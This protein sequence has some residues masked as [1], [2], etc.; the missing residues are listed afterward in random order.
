MEAAKRLLEKG[1]HCIPL[2]GKQPIGEGWQ[3]RIIGEAEIDTAFPSGC[4]LGLLLGE[5]SGWIVDID[6]DTPEAVVTAKYLMPPTGLSFGRDGV[7]RAHLLYV[8]PEMKTSKYKDPDRVKD[9]M[10]IEIRSTGGQTM[11]PPSTHPNGEKVRWIDKGEPAQLAVSTLLRGV[12]QT[13]SAA[14]LAM[15]WPEG[16]RQEAAMHLSGALARAGW[17]IADI[18][19]FIEAVVVAAGDD[20][21]EMRLKV[22]DYAVSKLAKGEKI[23]GWP[24]LTETL[25]EKVVQKVR[26]WMGITSAQDDFSE[27]FVFNCTD[28]GNAERLIRQHGEDIRFCYEWGKWVIWNGKQWEI[29]TTGEIYRRAKET[30]RGIGQEASRILDDN[31][32]KSVLKWASTSES[33]ARQRDMIALAESSQ[34]VTQDTLDQNPWLL[35]VQNG[36][37]DLRTGTLLPHAKEHLLTKLCPAKFTNQVSKKWQVFIERVLPD[38]DVRDF[39]QRAVGYSLTGDTGEEVMMFL[40]GTGRNGKSKFIEALQHVLGDYASST[41]PEVLMEK[42]H[43]SIPV[44]LAALKGVRFT[45]TVET[46][47]GQRFAES[48]IKQVTGGDELQVRHMRQDPFTYKPQ[49]KIW[50]ASNHKPDIRGRDQGIWSRILLVPFTV[51]IPPEERDRHLGEKLKAEADGILAWAVEGCLMWQRDGLKPPKQVQ[52]A[53][54]EY[55]DET[56]RLSEFFTDCCILNPLAKDTTKNLY[57]TY[58]T[59]CDLNAEEPIRKHTFIKMLG[60]RGLAP[61]RIGHSQ[62]R[63]WQGIKVGKNM[64]ENSNEADIFDLL[65]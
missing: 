12:Q 33:R 4:N 42:K 37:I 54:Q 50:L 49:F 30:V 65:S 29:D 57:E 15:H 28:M 9:S 45:S 26:E 23:T 47:Q 61:V 1:W 51:T 60:E 18:K 56:D 3:S 11:I 6:C 31:V 52:E 7:G 64:A 10:I 39:V 40:Y 53:V 27:S 17:E 5:P 43:D 25:G 34:P 48:L 62:A 24:T 41:R 58:R 8:C 63:G 2:R 20:E 55:Q 44:E 21:V 38:K 32:R 16:A 22:V 59:W 14:L 35:N 46:G 19:T 36:T 13:A